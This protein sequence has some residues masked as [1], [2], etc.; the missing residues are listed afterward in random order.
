MKKIKNGIKSPKGITLTVLAVTII[1]MLI[2]VTVTLQILIGK[3]GI[4]SQ[5]KRAKSQT[6]IEEEK[7]LIGLSYLAVENKK[8]GK[9]DFSEVTA[10]ELNEELKNNL[11]GAVASRKDPIIITIGETIYTLWENGQVKGPK[12]D[13]AEIII[14]EANKK[15]LKKDENAIFKIQTDKESKINK[16]KVKLEG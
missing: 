10:E 2:L 12:S 3:N 16:G 7:E 1:V 9:G 14:S 8:V 4:F 6:Q 11:K 13:P 15:Y 5:T